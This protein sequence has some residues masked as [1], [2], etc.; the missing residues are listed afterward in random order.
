MC[1]VMNS[2]P[3]KERS[4]LPLL[5]EIGQSQACRGLALALVAQAGEDQHDDGDDVGEHLVELLHGQVHAGGNV[6]VQ[7]VQPA[8]EE[9]GQHADVRPPYREDDQRDGQPAAVAEGVVGPYAAGVVHDVV[10]A[11]EAG[12]HAAD[13]GGRVLVA[14][15][16]DAGSIRRVGVLTHG[17]QVQSEA[18][19]PQD[20]GDDERDG[21]GDVSEESV[22][23]EQLAEDAALVRKGQGTVE[24]RAGGA[25]R[26]GGH[27]AAG[28]LDEGAAEEVADAHAEGGERQAGH[29]LV[30]AQG[31]GEEAVDKPGQ[32]RA[33]QAGA[34]RDGD[35]QE[36]V[37][38]RRGGQG[39]LVEEGA[40]DAADAADVHDAGNAEV[41]VA[42]FLRQ[43]LA[44]AAEE[45]RDALHD[46]AGNEGNEIEHLI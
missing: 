7:D 37:H 16:V 32:Q 46:G 5:S 30:G 15:D 43:R 8:E 41:E 13:A 25:E 17:A 23:E 14:P 40:D 28:Q 18:R 45:Q 10:E 11:A 35:S 44:G 27:R 29:V 42:G 31:D 4:G 21:D 20:V 9:G 38:V 24:V 12:D 22:G 33:Q 3:K 19:V 6:H 26:D 2:E 1:L 39:L 36:A 34:K